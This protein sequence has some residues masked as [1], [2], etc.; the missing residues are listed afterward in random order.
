M[1]AV[2]LRAH[3]DGEQIRLDEP[4]RLEPD[5]PLAIT[6]L[7]KGETTADTEWLLLSSEGL[8]AAYGDAEP[9]YPLDLIR[10]PNPDYDGG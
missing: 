6:I 4:F 2:T 10:E 9:D 5:T 1:K 8:E 3:F 7:P